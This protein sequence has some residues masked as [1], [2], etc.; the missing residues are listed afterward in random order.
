M[1]GS[2]LR[3]NSRKNTNMPS[4]FNQNT[5]ELKTKTRDFLILDLTAIIMFLHRLRHGLIHLSTIKQKH[6]K[7]IQPTITL[8]RLALLIW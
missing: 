2:Q 6:Y 1:D 5:R 3:S 8:Q 7:Q 4:I